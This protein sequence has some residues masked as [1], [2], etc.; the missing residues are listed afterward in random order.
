MI[1]IFI[2]VTKNIKNVQGNSKQKKNIFCSVSSEAQTYYGPVQ[3]TLDKFN[4]HLCTH[5]LIDNNS[6]LFSASIS[7]QLKNTNSN[8]KILLT[9]DSNENL[10][11][12]QWN[13]IIK[14]RKADGINIDI[15]ANTF[16]DDFLDKIKV[17][18]FNKKVFLINIFLDH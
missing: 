10:T 13:E 15:D 8:L 14:N 2:L 4:P 5:L 9:F 6:T 17:F 3:F 12:E 1:H 7:D 18:S 16:S 11:G